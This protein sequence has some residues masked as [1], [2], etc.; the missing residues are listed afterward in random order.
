ME[1]YMMPIYGILVIGGISSFLNFRLQK[2]WYEDTKED[3][4]GYEGGGE[5]PE[6]GWNG[7]G[8]K[9]WG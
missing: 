8:P 9:A 7:Q 2:R 3:P 4:I 1:W 6:G 5:A